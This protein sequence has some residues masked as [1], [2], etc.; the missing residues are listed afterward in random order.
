MRKGAV[1][2]RDFLLGSLVG[3]GAMLGASAGSPGAS[4]ARRVRSLGTFRRRDFAELCGSEFRFDARGAGDAVM[5]LVEAA[6]IR[7]TSPEHRRHARCEPFSA[8]FELR[9]GARL[10]QGTYRVSQRALGRFDLFVVP[11]GP[12][13]GRYEAVFT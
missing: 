12:E 7:L 13:P 6:P 5:A 3:C 10:P 9:S 1:R 2:R 8:L 4:A 11:V